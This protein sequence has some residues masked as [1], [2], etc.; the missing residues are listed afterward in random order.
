[1]GIIIDKD[2]RVIVQGITGREGS[3]HTA[4]M[5]EYGTKVTGGVT[6]GKGGTKVNGLP[7]FDTVKES[8][9][10]TSADASVIFVPP[11]F[12][13][14]A[15]LEAVFAGIRIIVCIT[16]GIPVQDMLK[17]KKVADETDTI[18]IGPN[19]PGLINVGESK[20]G[21]LPDN[22]F[23]K[24]PVGLISRSGTLTYEV[25]DELTRRGLGQTT[26]IGIG[27]DPVTGTSFKRLLKL[28][29]EDDETEVIVLIGEIGGSMEEEAAEFIKTSKKPVI[30]FIAGKTA[31]EG[32]RMGHAGAIISGSSG[33]AEGKIEAFLQAGVPVADTVPEIAHMVETA[34][35]TKIL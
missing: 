31:P 4:R 32:K 7:V 25:V 9:K 22:I 21:I 23:T 18:M 5:L 1:M 34:L 14:E 15:V 33:T 28:F 19:C 10:I 6:P 12:A 26:C 13:A 17:I 8:V 16:E 2:T 27:G 20:M 35:N 3:F 24:G 11:A 30:A 29:E